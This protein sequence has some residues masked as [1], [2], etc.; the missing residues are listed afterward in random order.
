MNLYA[1]NRFVGRLFNGYYRRR[2]VTI[3]AIFATLISKVL[4][5]VR[6]VIRLKPVDLLSKTIKDHPRKAIPSKNQ[7]EEKSQD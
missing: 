7:R 3:F 5:N 2:L 4:P 1:A 6:K